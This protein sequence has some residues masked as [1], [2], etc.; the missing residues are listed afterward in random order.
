METL[1]NE[2]RKITPLQRNAIKRASYLGKKLQEDHP[3]IADLFVEHT[4]YEIIDLLDIE[5]NYNVTRNVA[6]SGLGN[7][8]SGSNHLDYSYAGLIPKKEAIEL[9]KKHQKQSASELGN[10]LKDNKLGIF[11][12]TLER[13]EKQR[14]ASRETGIK[15]KEEERGIFSLGLEEQ[16]E[17]SRL[18]NIAQGRFIWYEGIDTPTDHLNYALELADTPEYQHAL[19]ARCGKAR[20]RPNWEKI[21]SKL[22]S[23]TGLELNTK[24]VSQAVHKHKIK[25]GEFKPKKTKPRFTLDEIGTM[26]DLSQKEEFRRGSLLNGT[27]LADKLNEL[28][29]NSEEIRTSQ[30]VSIKLSRLGNE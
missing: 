18:A 23:N 20:G 28:Y 5:S 8:L 30:S 11:D 2:V 24:Q 26:Q 16:I 14:N 9:G 22:N 25:T 19:D 13:T 1:A 12:P 4:L 17:A 3:E 7:A 15:N 29:H 10:Y 27:K 21:T 6:R